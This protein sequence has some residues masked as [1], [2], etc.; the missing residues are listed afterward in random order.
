MRKVCK[1]CRSFTEESNCPVCKGNQFTNTWQGRINVIDPS[2]SEIAK[3]CAI[4]A[5]GDYAIKVR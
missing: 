5:K 1:T 3:K 4:A 2:K